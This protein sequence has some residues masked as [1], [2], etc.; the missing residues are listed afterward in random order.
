MCETWTSDSGCPRANQLGH[1]TIYEFEPFTIKCLKI[2]NLFVS[3]KK[4]IFLR[5]SR[6]NTI[7]ILNLNIVGGV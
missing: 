1:L 5:S 2:N 3:H 4:R 7:L 6:Q